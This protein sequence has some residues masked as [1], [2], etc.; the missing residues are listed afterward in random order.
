MTTAI[1]LSLLRK[2]K[3]QDIQSVP[4]A[5]S[6]FDSDTLENK[7]VDDAVDL[8]FSVPNL[9]VDIFG[10][11][12][13][14]VGDL[15]ISATSE[16]GLGYHVNGVYLGSAA[17]EAEYYDVERIE[18]L[19]G[20]QGTLYGRNT[21][22]GVLNIITKKA[23]D[24]FEGYVTAGYGNFDS[25]K[26]RGALNLP[27]TDGLST[28]VAGFYLDRSGYA[29][30]VFTGNDVDD[31]KMFGLRSS[32]KL[33]F[34]DTRADF[35]VSYFKEDDQRLVRTKVLCEK[36]AAL[37]CSPLQRGFGTPDSRGTLFNT[38]GALTGIIATGFGPAA[39]D[40]Y[41]NSVNPTDARLINEDVDPTYFVEEWS[42][43][44][45]I[46]HD[47][48][49]ISLTSLS[50]Y[51]EIERGLFKD[52]DRFVPSAG[53]TRPI[54]FDF[55]ANG[56][57]ITTTNILAGR[58]D[59]SEA[60]EYYQELRLASDFA[61]P[62]NF[63]VG[64]NYYNRRS[65][66]SAQFTHVTIAAR[67]QVAGL[68]DQFDSLIT[69]SNP[70]RTKSF[71]IFGEVYFDLSDNTSLTGGLRYSHDDKTIQTRQIFFNPQADGSLPPFVFG[72]FKKGVVTGRVVLDHKFSPDLLGYV[73]ASRGY[74]AGGINPNEVGVESQGFDP[75]FLNAFEVGLKGSS[76]DGTFTANVSAFYYDYKD[77]QIGQTTATSA[78]TVNTDAKVWGVEAEFALRPSDRF[79]VDGSFS[80]LNTQIKNF[81]SIDETDP[82]GTAPGT[83]VSA[84]TAAGVLKGV[85]GNALPFSPDVKIAIGAQYEIPVGDWLLTP[86]IDHYLQSEFAGS[87]FSK[88]IDIFDGYSQTDIKLLLAPGDGNWEIRGYV[89]NLFNN[90]DITRVLPAG[91]LV[92]RFREVVILEPRTYGI[93][94]TFRF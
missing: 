79:Q 85:D 2:K 49:D 82:F 51:Q 89:K 15:A 72:E 54:T 27:I 47:F 19:R 92:G 64:G 83:V 5:I 81:A 67:Q 53:L 11:S 22:A 20:P 55:F 42:A 28:R 4:I 52:F 16:S 1:S 69:E 86:R 29:T 12:L 59:M 57:P 7:V 56:N 78:L 30:N 94:G 48:G 65:S 35:V 75:E 44:L 60:R 9:T 41:A 46:N 87:I 76:I 63:I 88:P 38:F 8:S 23:T 93:E 66:S 50:G 13:R 70:V 24:D 21:T 39:V 62:V 6:A 18:V 68:S 45:E 40:Y 36:D 3:S 34:G 80:Y 26:L 17:T 37:G 61:G 91:R 14:G 25:I 77:L 74:K 31:R 73:S 43:S 32:T 58:R 90:D 71:G 84:V 10:A 33:E